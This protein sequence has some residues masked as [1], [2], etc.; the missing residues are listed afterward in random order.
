MQRIGAFEGGLAK[1]SYH[2]IAGSA[3]GELQGLQGEGSTSVGHGME[4]PF[5]L[6]YELPAR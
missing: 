5:T 2:V 4:H 6:A 3:S 1:E